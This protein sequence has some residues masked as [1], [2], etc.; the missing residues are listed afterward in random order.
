[1]TNNTN[2][3]ELLINFCKK[4]KHRFTLSGKQSP[5]PIILHLVVLINGLNGQNVNFLSMRSRFR[6]RWLLD[7]IYLGRWSQYV[8]LLG[9]VWKPY[10]VLTPNLVDICASTKSP[11]ILTEDLSLLVL[12]YYWSCH[13][14]HS[15]PGTVTNACSA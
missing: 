6:S 5:P 4:K 15:L 12:F 14:M 1:M 8:T 7:N 9:S 13:I 11:V 3:I 2:T 10:Y